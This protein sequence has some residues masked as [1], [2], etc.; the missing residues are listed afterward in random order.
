MANPFHHL[1]RHT[2]KSKLKSIH[3]H[4]HKHGGHVHAD[5]A[6]DKAMI[7]AAMHKHEHKMHGKKAG[8]RL[9]RKHKV[10]IQIE[11]SGDPSMAPGAPGLP[12]TGAMPSPTAL[13]PPGMSSGPMPQIG[14]GGMQKR[15]GRV[16]HRKHGGRIKD[17]PESILSD[18]EQR[19]FLQRKRKKGGRVYTEGE[20]TASNLSK[21]KGYASHNSYH[22]KRASGGRVGK[23][24][25]KRGG[26]GSGVGR[27]DLTH[28][29]RKTYP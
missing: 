23:Y 26:A 28:A 24:P 15:G 17:Q 16:H 2:A 10:K 8:G 1:A 6:E 22:P 9:D 13:P 11:K 14:P 19:A 21:W 25:L 29:E 20:S 12:G 4:H 5:A 3:R 27:M 18:K 7:R